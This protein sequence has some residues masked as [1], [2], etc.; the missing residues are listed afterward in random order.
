MLN[1]TATIV[2]SQVAS[3]DLHLIQGDIIAVDKGCELLL[4][5]NKK[6]TQAIGDFDSIQPKFFKKLQEKQVPLTTFPTNKDHSDAELALNWVINKGYTVIRMIGFEGGRLDHYQ[7]IIQM[8]FRFQHAGITLLTPHQSIQYLQKGIYNLKKEKNEKYF[9]IFTLS[10]ADISIQHARYP[11]IK[12][13]LN[14]KDTFT[15]SNEWIENQD[16]TLT[17]RAGEVLLYRSILT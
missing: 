7:A 10:N 11:L 1:K 12:K 13:E 2:L 5:K 15:L 8:L 17:I 6:I 4:K 16:V 14:V 3:S 9:S